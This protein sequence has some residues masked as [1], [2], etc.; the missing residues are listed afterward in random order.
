M[1][2][3][4]KYQLKTCLNYFTIIKDKEKNKDKDSD[5]ENQKEKDKGKES[6][7]KRE[8]INTSPDEIEKKMMH[9]RRD[10]TRNW[11]QIGEEDKKL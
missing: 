9:K 11:D 1:V 4:T 10:K 7:K 6:E 5:K 2:I 3:I 8:S